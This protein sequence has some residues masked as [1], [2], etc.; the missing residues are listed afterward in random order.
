MFNASEFFPT[1]WDDGGEP[2]EGLENINN[3]VDMRT[4]VL[5]ILIATFA[6]VM[7]VIWATVLVAASGK[8]ELA[9]KWKSIITT[10]ILG[11]LIWLAAYVI[12]AVL[13]NFIDA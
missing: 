5:V 8:Q 7:I 6:T 9:Q 1:A 11:L 3:M 13:A 12:V 4:P 2:A 10:A